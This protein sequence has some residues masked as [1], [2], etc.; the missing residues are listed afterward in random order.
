M[1]ELVIELYLRFELE[2]IQSIPSGS[3]HS[4]SLGQKNSLLFKNIHVRW[5]K[6]RL[7]VVVFVI[8]CC[9]VLI[10]PMFTTVSFPLYVSTVPD[11]GSN[12]MSPFWIIKDLESSSRVNYLGTAESAVRIKIFKDKSE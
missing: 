8:E 9:N 5:F 3:G 1:G 7:D 2:V 4:V 6:F 11:I 10:F 12:L